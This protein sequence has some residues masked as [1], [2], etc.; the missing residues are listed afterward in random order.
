MTQPFFRYI[1]V[2]G[3]VTLIAGPVAGQTAA[4][5]QTGAAAKAVAR[6]AD[7]QPDLQGVWNVAAGTPLERPEANNARDLTMFRGG[8]HKA[9]IG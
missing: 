9:L 8:D 1:G 6:T 7:G 5:P 3:F 4:K 2:L